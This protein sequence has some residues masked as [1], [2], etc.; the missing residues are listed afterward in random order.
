MNERPTSHLGKP[1]VLFGALAVAACTG[2]IA[3]DEPAEMG[4]GDPFRPNDTPGTGS[5]PPSPDTV[6]RRLTRTEYSNTVRDLLGSNSGPGSLLDIDPIPREGV[7]DNDAA[8]LSTIEPS[9]DKYDAVSSQ[10][11]EE[12]LRAGSA[13]RAKLLVGCNPLAMA[14]ARTAVSSFARR[15]WRRPVDEA[16][17][18]RLMTA[19]GQVQAEGIEAVVKLA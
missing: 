8:L 17:M 9:A 5:A 16:E 13:T 4:M 12:A 18:D 14:C 1:L 19:A 10:L 6:L 3:G 7:F 2:S 11:V 15:A